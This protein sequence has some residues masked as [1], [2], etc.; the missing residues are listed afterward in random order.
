MCNLYTWSGTMKEYPSMILN[1]YHFFLSDGHIL[2]FSMTANHMVS[3]VFFIDFCGLL[4]LW[5][6]ILVGTGKICL[7]GIPQF[8]DMTSTVQTKDQN[9]LLKNANIFQ[10]EIQNKKLFFVFCIYILFILKWSVGF[11]ISLV[12]IGNLF[13]YCMWVDILITVAP[14][15]LL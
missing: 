15:P 3:S 1:F 6:V 11:I 12:C 4:E 7:S 9:V 5:W 13:I 8:P 2:S 10:S 14:P